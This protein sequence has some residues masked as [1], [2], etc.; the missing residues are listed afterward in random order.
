[1]TEQARCLRDLA[2]CQHVL[3]VARERG[4]TREQWMAVLADLREGFRQQDLEDE[5]P[6]YEK[7]YEREDEKNV[8]RS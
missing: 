1:M 2:A 3:S 8:S 4:W 5:P 7:L 6:P